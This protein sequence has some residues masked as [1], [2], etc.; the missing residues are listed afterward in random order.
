MVRSFCT[1][2]G[3]HSGA[4]ADGFDVLVDDDVPGNAT[5]RALDIFSALSFQGSLGLVVA[6]P[7]C[8]ECNGY[9]CTRRLV[10]AIV[11]FS[12]FIASST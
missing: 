4:V 6:A 8:L 10:A 11:A 1:A 9:L 12:G 7:S 5:L 3:L 2:R